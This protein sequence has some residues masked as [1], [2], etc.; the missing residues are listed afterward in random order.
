MASLAAVV[1]GPREVVAG[2]LAGAVVST[3]GS[4]GRGGGVGSCFQVQSRAC[5]QASVSYMSAPRG[6]PGA[7]QLISPRARDQRASDRPMREASGFFHRLVSVTP[8]TSAGF[9]S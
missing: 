2:R 7:L 6:R 3:E 1:F 5:W 8:T 4:T 9:R